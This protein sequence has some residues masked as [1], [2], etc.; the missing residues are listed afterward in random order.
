METIMPGLALV[1]FVA[2]AI[3]LLVPVLTNRE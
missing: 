3:Y 1:A 2:V